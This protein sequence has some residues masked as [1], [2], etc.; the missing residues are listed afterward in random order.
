M[1]RSPDQE[2]NPEVRAALESRF[3]ELE[4]TE[5]APQE[6]KQEV[7]NTLETL[8]LVADLADLFTVKF[9]KTKLDFLDITTR[10][11]AP[12]PDSDDVDGSVR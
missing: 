2:E 10:K 6:L 1:R 5:N 11:E 3:Q 8:Q 7:F 9:S 12:R 4:P